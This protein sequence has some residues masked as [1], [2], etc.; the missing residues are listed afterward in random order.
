MPRRPDSVAVGDG[1]GAAEAVE[2]VEAAEPVEVAE[3]AEFAEFAEAAESVEVVESV[4]F[5]LLEESSEAEFPEAE[6]APVASSV[7]D[8]ELDSAA[9][10]EADADADVDAVAE[11]EADADAVADAAELDDDVVD[12]FDSSDAASTDV[13]KRVSSVCEEA[14]DC[15]AAKVLSL[16]S[17]LMP[18]SAGTM[19][20]FCAFCAALM[21]VS[22][23][24]QDTQW[25][26]SSELSTVSR[27]E[28][29]LD[30]SMA[31]KSREYAS[32]LESLT[33][34]TLPS[35]VCAM[36]R[37][38]RPAVLFSA[39]AALELAL[40]LVREES[41]DSALSMPTEPWSVMV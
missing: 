1:D 25:A 9:G 32:E 41:V 29:L 38:M 10:D 12:E 31:M 17:G 24:S 23:E 19:A 36:I 8:G 3:A 33:C 37:L 4:A 34:V 28:Q 39:V 11:A 20:S 13:K 6:S 40:P 30:G 14:R 22:K 27:S 16:V 35:D 2:F 18:E 5:A 7:A 26:D 21:S 15:A